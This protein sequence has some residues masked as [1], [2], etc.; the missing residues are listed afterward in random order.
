MVHLDEQ[1]FGQY[2][3]LQDIQR[4]LD[5]LK[6]LDLIEKLKPTF[7]KDGNQFCFL[8]GELPNDCVI[9]FGDTAALAMQDFY[10][11]YWTNKAIVV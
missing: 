2:E 10:N 8:Y 5:T 11:N 3:L 7:S 1:Q 4:R 9:G 6:E